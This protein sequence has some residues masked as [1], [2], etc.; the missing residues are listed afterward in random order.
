M[1][2]AAARSPWLAAAWTGVGTAVVGCTVAIAA[3]AVCWLPTSGSSGHALSAL[4]A[5]LLAFLASVHGGI[6]V[7]A[8][9]GTFLPLG[10]TILL[11]LV[12]YRAGQALADTVDEQD[13]TRLVVIGLAQLGS[14][15]AACLVL[16]PLATLG[17]SRAPFLGV[18]CLAALLFLV[19]GAVAFVRRSPL[20]ELIAERIPAWPGPALRAA[21]AGLTVYL[22][23]GALLVAGSLV[24]HH[25]EVQ[26]LQRA[27][28][29]GWNGAP[30][31]LLC[32]LA[33]PNAV[34]AGA[35]VLAGPG[36][37]VGTGTAVGVGANTHGVLP[38]FPVLGAL[39]SGPNPGWLWW[40]VVLVALV[41]GAVVAG[42]ASR[43]DGWG[44]R[45]RA[46]ATTAGVAALGGMVLAWQGGGSLGEGR[47][48]TVGASPWQFGLAVGAEL[49]VAGA[50]FLGLRA[51]AA[52]LRGAVDDH[53]SSVGQWLDRID[54]SA[55][56]E[57]MFR[58]A[59]RDDQRDADGR[60]SDQRD[61]AD[62]GDRLAG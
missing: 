54:G 18:G 57:R 59:D 3:V 19:T 14:F 35:S 11:G 17:T 48:R 28:G 8:T 44:A 30:V 32:L 41:A 46:L 1:P 53:G 16:V 61:D 2:E 49:A 27:A 47:L 29:P 10:M 51:A 33:A 45:F 6:T 31:L 21:A 4:R 12:A 40:A 25:S 42:L 5:G 62:G 13:P 7:D 37:A 38:A 15:V 56:T 24:M 34:I 55:V 9:S 22:G 58:G 39:P 23:T 26:A 20:S 60:D 50:V 36:F 43:A 52:A